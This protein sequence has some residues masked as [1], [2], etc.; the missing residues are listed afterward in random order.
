MPGEL[1]PVGQDIFGHCAATSGIA[2]ALA[3][4]F[5]ESLKS[6][7]LEF[8]LTGQGSKGTTHGIQWTDI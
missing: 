1:I 6:V 2:N 3:L 8:K 5:S 4:F 7:G